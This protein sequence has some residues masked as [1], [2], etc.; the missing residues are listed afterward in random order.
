MPSSICGPPST[1]PSTAYLHVP[2]DPHDPPSAHDPHDPLDPDDPDDPTYRNRMIRMARMSRPTGMT[3]MS[4]TIHASRLSP[5]TRATATA[6]GEPPWVSLGQG[7]VVLP[8]PVLDADLQPIVGEATRQRWRSRCGWGGLSRS[9]SKVGADGRRAASRS[10][11]GRTCRS[12]GFRACLGP[13]AT[14][15][16]RFG[17]GPVGT[18][19][20]GPDMGPIGRKNTWSTAQPTGSRGRSGCSPAPSWGTTRSTFQTALLGRYP[21]RWGR[22]AGQLTMVARRDRARLATGEL[23]RSGSEW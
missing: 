11:E 21:G 18:R 19:R 1:T 4:L 13:R 8:I 5:T 10:R 7:L 23:W 3:R 6:V 2:H 14:R 15:R 20:V 16:S 12:S 9:R 17:A 22:G